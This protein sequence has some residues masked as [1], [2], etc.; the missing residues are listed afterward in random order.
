MAITKAIIIKIKIF[1]LYLEAYL[2][3]C[4]NSSLPVSTFICVDSTFVDIL[5]KY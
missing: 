1:F 5:S 3:A 2:V 4:L